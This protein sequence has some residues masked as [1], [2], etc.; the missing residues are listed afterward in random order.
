MFSKKE[1]VD[2]ASQAHSEFIKK[3]KVNCKIS[4]V[5]LNEFWNLAKKSKL[6]QA[7][8]KQKIPLKIGAIVLHSKKDVICLNQ[9]ILNQIAND[10]DFVKAIVIHELY[11]VLLKNKVKEDSLNEEVKSENRVD[12][13]LTKEFPNYSKF[14]I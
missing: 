6:V 9:E 11:H 7:D 10:P 5:S 12:D 13:Y 3:H 8:I 2:L 4:L 14:F 1:I